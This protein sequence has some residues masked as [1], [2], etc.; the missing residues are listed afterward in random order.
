[1]YWASTRFSNPAMS[2]AARFTQSMGLISPHWRLAW[3]TLDATFATALERRGVADPVVLGG[4]SC[5]SDR[6]ELRDVLSSLGLF[7]GVAFDEIE[8]RVDCAVRLSETARGVALS[9]LGQHLDI[10]P[11]Y[12]HMD[13]AEAAKRARL[14]EQDASRLRLRAPTVR[15][16]PTQWK[17]KRYLRLEKE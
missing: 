15:A 2:F 16:L 13:R 4:I 5:T 1:M 6:S 7:G 9:A 12:F 17:G 11:E 10:A 3:G 14:E 8:A